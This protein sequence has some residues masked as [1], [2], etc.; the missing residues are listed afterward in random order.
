MKNAFVIAAVSIVLLIALNVYYYYDTFKWQ[1]ATQQK[2]LDKELIICSDQIDQFF[3][4]TQTNVLLL[5]SKHE[6]RKFFKN[7]GLAI[8]TQKRIELLYNRYDDFLNGLKV[9][10][11]HGTSYTLRR[12]V[13]GTTISFF[14]KTHIEDAFSSRIVI[15]PEL[16][17]II[18]LQPLQIDSEIY[19]FVEFNINMSHFFSVFMLNYNLEEYQFQWVVNSESEIIYATVDSLNIVAHNNDIENRLKKKLPFERVHFL[20]FDGKTEKVISVFRPLSF[21]DNTYYLGFSLPVSL[22]TASIAKNTFL[23]G[24]IT[25]LIILFIIIFFALYLKKRNEQDKMMKLTQ[26]AL[27]KM[28][29]YLP[30]GILMIDN[31]NKIIQVNRAFMNLFSI[32]DEDSL[33]GHQFN[34]T[35]LFENLTLVEKVK[36]TDYSYKYEIK[37]KNNQQSVILN[38]KIPFYLQSE[39]FLVD[40]YTELPLLNQP[41]KLILDEKT[42]KTTFI[43][44]ISH[45]LRT[46]LNGIIGMTDL[47]SHT[48]IGTSEAD[49]LSVLKR[50]ADMLLSLINDILDFSKIES[51]KFDIESIPFD[52]K[53]E[54]DEVI[55][56]FSP[57]A[58][59]RKLNL[60]WHYSVVLP[61]DFVGDP[62]RFRQIL[63]NLISNALKFTEK[64]EVQLIVS[65]T[66][67]LNG[68][69]ALL[70]AVRDTGIGIP[71]EKQKSIFRSF[72]QVDESTTRR[73]GGT[74]LGTTISKE[75]VGLMGGEI[76][77]N[78]PCDL[79]A[80][81]DYPGTE[82]CFTLPVKTRRQAKNLSFIT[83]IKEFSQIKA[84][85]VTD[86][87][88]QMQISSRNLMALKIDYKILAPSQ[89]TIDLL[90]TSNKYHLIIIDNRPD[91]SGM[92]FLHELFN[93]QLHN[94]HII[95]FQSSDNQK[96]NTNVVKRLGA[97]AYLRKPV[98]FIVLRD[99]ILKHF[100]SI[101]E[102]A[103]IE[104]VEW[105]E[106]LKI[107]VAED[108][109]LNQRVAQNIFRK[110]G[111]DIELANDGHEAIQKALCTNY[112]IIFM[113]I[114]MP[115]MDGIAAVK[116]LKKHRKSCPVVAMTASNDHSERERAFAAG[117]DDYICK[118]AKVEEILRMLT[119]WC[120]N[121]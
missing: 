103:P 42:A 2:V 90:R 97:D 17:Q 7:P 74:G 78:S 118:P 101:T 23:V 114:F 108:N 21:S 60:S 8:E 19:G 16:N 34:E 86:D 89:E 71:I 11:N 112:N 43:A 99:F 105:P 67:A 111:F 107:L 4:K 25:I 91:Y 58:K 38:E 29:Y 12:G 116:E 100:S 31:N 87:P 15:N 94:N 85:L 73:Y 119:K 77:V 22:V 49:M 56:L 92:D 121:N 75:L 50:S 40:V 51:G 30:A 13:N 18:Y 76:W 33:L 66:R 26:D 32:D 45:E 6:M 80:D 54:I 82:F 5:L 79:S 117:M 35:L 20:K 3:Q 98:R 102:K 104:F 83:H 46:P 47:L 44:N 63:N 65:K 53:A 9:Y 88:M 70:F 96:T 81:P 55:D 14:E 24:G 120:A 93:H 95:L 62:V 1:I 59:A 57:Q 68:N 48:N 110:I 52:I 41:S 10:N 115:G 28:I 64:G 37:N 36:Y 61:S 72:Y 39:R 109:Q 84:L 106:K 27:K 69:P 113:D